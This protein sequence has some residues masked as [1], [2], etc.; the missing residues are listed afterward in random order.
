VTFRYAWRWL[1]GS[2]NAAETAVWRSLNQRLDRLELSHRLAA[3]VP[4]PWIHRHRYFCVLVRIARCGHRL[5]CACGDRTART[6]PQP[7][8]RRRTGPPPSRP[9]CL[10]AAVGPHLRTVA[11]LHPL[12]VGAMRII[13]LIMDAL[14]RARHPRPRRRAEVGANVRFF[15]G[16]LAAT[17][18]ER[19]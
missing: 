2:R 4:P 6:R 19:R 16:R 14:H 11:P 8:T 5:G 1:G 13:A 18:R 15:R 7:G 17:G 3:L 10:G 12:C 9:L